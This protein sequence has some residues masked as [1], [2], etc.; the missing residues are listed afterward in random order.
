[1]LP[2][3]PA[4]PPTLALLALH[5]VGLC[6]TALALQAQHDAATPMALWAATLLAGSMAHPLARDAL[7]AGR[8]RR[9]AAAG[10]TFALTALAFGLWAS[11]A[12]AIKASGPDPAALL[13][14]AW[15][16]A[17]GALAGALAGRTAADSWGAAAWVALLPLLALWAAPLGVFA[18]GLGAVALASFIGDAGP[19]ASAPGSPRTAHPLPSGLSAVAVGCQVGAALLFQPD[20]AAPLALAALFG[21]AGSRLAAA[22]L[23]AFARTQ[24]DTPTGVLRAPD[25][26]LAQRR[27]LAL[28][29][30]IGAACLLATVAP[31]LWSGAT[32]APM[33]GL[34]ALAVAATAASRLLM[35]SDVRATLAAQLGAGALGGL[36]AGPEGG[37]LGLCVG[38]PALAGLRGALRPRPPGLA[39]TRPAL[40]ASLPAVA[41]CLGL[42]ATHAP[43][44]PT[45]VLME[46]AAIVIVHAMAGLAAH[47]LG[48]THP[49]PMA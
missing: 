7:Q 29:L 27:S 49:P 22:L 33:E 43:R 40:L 31:R 5:A 48:A 18:L 37:V 15:T 2:A 32:G 38:A 13:A 8:G 30:S 25:E 9:L 46:V 39:G 3:L 45:D 17:A 47:H 1:M 34:L 6:A 4:A 28:H 21:D 26:P 35:G 44:T 24:A 11:G 23:A 20:W 16:I 14:G 42:A 12:D 10:M 19:D 36:V 41:L